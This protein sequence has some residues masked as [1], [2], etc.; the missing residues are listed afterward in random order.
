MIVDAGSFLPAGFNAGP[1]ARVEVQGGSVGK[2]FEAVGAEVVAT[3]GEFQGHIDLLEGSSLEIDGAHV[4]YGG[5]LNVKYDSRLALRSG[6][7]DEKI[8]ASHGGYV[9]IEGGTVTTGAI[10]REVV[11][12]VG[13]TVEILG[14]TV[15]NAIRAE[16]GGSLI[17]R[18]GKLGRH[19]RSPT[20][21]VTVSS[22]S[23]VL[24][25]GGHVTI[26]SFIVGAGASAVIRGGLID[27]KLSVLSGAELTLS[28]GE[29][30]NLSLAGTAILQGGFLN[31]ETDV[32]S[33]AL[34]SVHGLDFLLD[35]VPVPGLQSIGDSLLLSEREGK[36]LEF[37]LPDGSWEQL[38]LN[39]TNVSG[40]DYVDPLAQLWLVRDSYDG[41]F[42][43]DGDV[44]GRDFLAWQRN[45][46]LDVLPDWQSNYGVGTAS[47]SNASI[48]PEP[49]TM[50]LMCSV[51]MGFLVR[52]VPAP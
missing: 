14:G 43:L 50:V 49:A 17:I 28:G 19:S 33:T 27:S 35:G 44:D 6:S 26:S 24:M 12:D 30:N 52:R 16:D 15:G 38:T 47:S 9:R 11:A 41:D 39:P 32:S 18:G 8:T 42:D 13:G 3:A 22:G 7:I 21:A 29:V 34:L 23:E 20:V 5:E 31:G 51:L 46:T 2:H 1:G 45:P 36:L 40:A 10:D 25:T 48:V 37:L 4:R